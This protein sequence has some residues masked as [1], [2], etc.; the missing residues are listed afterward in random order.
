MSF[1]SP[2]ITAWMEWEKIN[3][4]PKARDMRTEII[5]EKQR[6]AAFMKGVEYGTHKEN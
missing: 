2:E 3:G 4:F 1:F 6:C 5:L